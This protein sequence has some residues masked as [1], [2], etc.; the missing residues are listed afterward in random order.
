MGRDYKRE[1]RLYYGVGD[2]SSVTP[3]QRKRRKEKASR[4]EAREKYKGK[5][6]GKDIHHVNGNALDN[7]PSNLRATSRAYNRSKNKH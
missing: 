5:K 1:Y 3:E 7:R 2:A 4:A 6:E